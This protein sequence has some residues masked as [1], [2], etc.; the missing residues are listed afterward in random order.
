[1]IRRPPRSTPL[2]SSAASDVYKRQI[3]TDFLDHPAGHICH[4]ELHFL[5]QRRRILITGE[6]RPI[7][8]PHRIHPPVHHHFTPEGVPLHGAH[9]PGKHALRQAAL[10]HISYLQG[11][12]ICLKQVRERLAQEV[13]VLAHLLNVVFEVHFVVDLE[14]QIGAERLHGLDPERWSQRYLLVCVLVGR[15]EGEKL[16]YVITRYLLLLQAAPVL[17]LALEHAL[18]GRPGEI[19]PLRQYGDDIRGG[20]V[21]VGYHR[22]RRTGRVL[23]DLDGFV[24]KRSHIVALHVTDI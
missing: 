1:M 24:N 13:Y 2:Y 5:R 16:R 17:V 22:R 8:L 3:Q 23:Y 18:Q 9:T 20:K 7:H 4:P 21:E 19:K 6:R 10:T 14:G 11:K 15:I 12:W